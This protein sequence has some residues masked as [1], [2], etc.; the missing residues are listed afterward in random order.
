MKLPYP[1]M[2]KAIVGGM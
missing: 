1:T 2:E